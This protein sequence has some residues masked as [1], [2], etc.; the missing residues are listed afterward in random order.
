MSSKDAKTCGITAHLPNGTPFQQ[1][2]RNGCLVFVRRVHGV[3]TCRAKDQ[4]S[5]WC[6]ES[7]CASLLSR[8]L[9]QGHVFQQCL[10][11]YTTPPP[12]RIVGLGS[13]PLSLHLENKTRSGRWGQVWRTPPPSL[14]ETWL[15]G[16]S[17]PSALIHRTSD[18]GIDQIKHSSQLNI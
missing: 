12:K 8:P 1:Q 16:I 2:E 9:V 6:P 17:Q 10:L 15:S 5:W 13:A 11:L 4:N 18:L 3:L 14:L 7:T